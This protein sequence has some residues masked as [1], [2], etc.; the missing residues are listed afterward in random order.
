MSVKINVKAVPS[1]G[2][3]ECIVDKV[4]VIKCF[5]KSPPEKGKAN[6]ELLKL[7]ANYL[8]IPVYC[9]EIVSGNT[10]RKK[11][12]KIEHKI[13]QSQ[14]DEVFNQ[15]RINKEDENENQCHIF[16]GKE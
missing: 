15:L 1:S 16:H 12:I 5:V 7:L 6:K 3:R 13:S 10:S 8:K 14:V 11:R 9:L 4:G 2:R